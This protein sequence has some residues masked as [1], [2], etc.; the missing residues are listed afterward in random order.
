MHQT[1]TDQFSNDLTDRALKEEVITLA[2]DDHITFD[3]I[4]RQTGCTEREVIAIMRS[5]LKA[6][7]FRMWRKRV[8]GR[9]SYKHGVLEGS[10]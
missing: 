2:W 6:S 4:Q 9:K 1:E 3:S 5:E 10:L 7:S 8:T